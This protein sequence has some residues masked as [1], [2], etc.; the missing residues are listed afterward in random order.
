MAGLDTRTS[1]RVRR[2]FW[3]TIFGWVSTKRR[4]QAEIDPGPR[5]RAPRNV[6]LSAGAP[7]HKGAP[8]IF[9]APVWPAVATLAGSTLTPGPMVEEIATRWI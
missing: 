3:L 5:V 6:Y 9:H 7:F 8:Q 4:K 2:P 1:P